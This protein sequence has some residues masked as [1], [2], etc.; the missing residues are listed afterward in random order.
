MALSYSSIMAKHINQ[1]GFSAHNFEALSQKYHPKAALASL[2]IKQGEEY[3]KKALKKPGKYDPALSVYNPGTHLGVVSERFALAMKNYIQKNPDG[4]P[5]EKDSQLSKNTARYAGLTKNKFKALMNLKY[6]HSLVEPGEAVGLLAAQSEVASVFAVYG[7]VVDRRHLTLIA[8]YM[9]F[10]GGYKPF[11]RIGIGSN[12][13]PFLKMSFESTCKFLTEATLH[14]DFDTL[15]SP[16]SRIVVGR[17]V[18]GGTG[19]FDV[20]QPLTST[21]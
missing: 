13:A 7:I 3:A 15:D 20:L 4:M 1:F 17:V 2:E 21:A 19:S 14:G 9:T 10:E 18:E 16:S 11:S 12:V 8:D 5:F 6:L